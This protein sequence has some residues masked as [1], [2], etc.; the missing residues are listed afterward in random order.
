[1]KLAAAFV[2][3]LLLC[4]QAENS[5]SATPDPIPS[6]TNVQLWPC[7]GG[8]FTMRQQWEIVSQSY[9]NTHIQLKY[10]QKVLDILD[11]SNTTGANLQ[12]SRIGL[13]RPLPTRSAHFYRSSFPRRPLG[14]SSLCTIQRLAKL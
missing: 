5:A 4:L 10:D 6:F 2:S 1:M 12:V 11:Y 13:G 7:T 9:P 14:I 3:L 8:V